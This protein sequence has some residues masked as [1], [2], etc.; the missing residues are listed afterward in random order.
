MKHDRGQDRERF[1]RFQLQ[2][3]LLNNP[4]FRPS[5]STPGPST[6]NAKDSRAE[7]RQRGMDSFTR[8]QPLRNDQASDVV[9]L[10]IHFN[11]PK[12]EVLY[13]DGDPMDFWSFVRNF[14]SH[15]DERVDGDAQKLSYLLQHC[16]DNARKLIEGCTRMRPRKGYGEARRLLFEKYI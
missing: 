16:T 7:P 3:P 4:Y 10:V 1:N 2:D 5:L 11:R 15:V 12:H 9:T 13:F 14:E 6:Q 8:T